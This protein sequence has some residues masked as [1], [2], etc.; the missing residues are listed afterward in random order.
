MTKAKPKDPQDERRSYLLRLAEENGYLDLTDKGDAGL[1]G[2][3]PLMFTMAI[4][5]DIGQYGYEDRWCY[6]S[7]KDAKAAFD[8]WDGA[9]GTEPTGWHRHPKTG[10]RRDENGNEEVY[11]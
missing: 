1:C 11:F 10:R 7:Y 9:D 3:V 6:K 8:A 5:A 4:V 2:I